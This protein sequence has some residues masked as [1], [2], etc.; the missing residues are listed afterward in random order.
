MRESLDKMT[1]I[2]FTLVLLFIASFLIADFSST[3]IG[4]N[5][6][7]FNPSWQFSITGLV[8]N[9]SNF[10]LA[11]LQN[12]T[13]TTVPAVLV[14]VSSPTT[15]LE[16]GNWQGVK[17]WTLLTQ[18]G[19]SSSASKIAL[20]AIDGFSTDLTIDVAKSDNIIVAYMLDGQPLSEVVRLVVPFHWGYKWINQI[21]SIEAV[22]NDYKGTYES[23]GYTDDGVITAPVPTLPTYSNPPPTFTSTPTNP[24]TTTP[25]GSP[26]QSSTPSSTASSTLERSNLN[27]VIFW[28]I[29][30]VA[31]ILVAVAV[32]ALVL[33]RKIAKN[34]N[35]DAE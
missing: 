19:I 32:S 11:N 8:S 26:N 13:Q 12:M 33:R 34:K 35:T 4:V 1:K 17:L 9:P 14:C 3:E 29:G 7:S 6:Q 5:A 16:Q 27:G 28:V 22:D 21:T 10:T 23:Q 31:A 20:H 18:A 25:N 15:V 24:Q 30:I 2:L